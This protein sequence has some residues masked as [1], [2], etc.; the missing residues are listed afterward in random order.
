MK[1]SENFQTVPV[2]AT[3]AGEP[4]P[5]CQRSLVTAANPSS[6]TA[7]LRL[8]YSVKEAS[9][10]LGVSEKSVRRLIVRGLLRPSR[11][12]RNLLIPRKEIDRFL[13]DT[14]GSDGE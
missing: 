8:A 13:D 5:E 6:G 9:Q 11:A 2:A 4:A 7:P 12:L 1:T 10:I 3:P 14:T